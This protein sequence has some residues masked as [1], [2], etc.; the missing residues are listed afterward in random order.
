M[1]VD[2]L[3]YAFSDS[4]A[5]IAGAT[6]VAT[7]RTIGT[8]NTTTTDPNGQ[9]FFTGLADDTYDVTVT[10]D[11]KVRK[12]KGDI[13]LQIGAFVNNAGALPVAD[14]SVTSAKLANGAVT[15][16]KIAAGAVN[17]TGLADGAITTNKLASGAVGT[18]T[19]AASAVTA[20]KLGPLSVG[21]SALQDGSVTQAKLASGVGGGGGGVIDDSVYTAAIQDLAVTTAK[22]ANN[23]VGSGQL[24]VGGVA[25][26]ALADGAVTAAKLASG[27]GG[28]I[29]NTATQTQTTSDRIIGTS[30]TQ[31]FATT[32]PA[33]TYLV[34]ANLDTEITGSAA[35]Q[36]TA[37]LFIGGVATGSQAVYTG[38]PTNRSVIAAAWVAVLT[39][40]STSLTVEAHRTS[41]TGAAATVHS[42]HSR[43]VLVKVA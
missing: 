25:T 36:V 34:L 5:P 15:A 28:G 41:T 14:S 37:E 32:L 27:V 18:G 23:A 39:G 4:G 38:D 42:G 2:L 11:G 6:V 1:A 9:W 35:T 30:S 19:I 31:V 20:A 22:I 3:N 43:L 12:Y 40:A 10:K 33:G 7:G 16:A 17:A 26:A 8:P 29:S 21:T 13:K 24:A